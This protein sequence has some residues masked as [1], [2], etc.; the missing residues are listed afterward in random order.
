[1]LKN[2]YVVYGYINKEEGIYKIKRPP[3]YEPRREIE[4]HWIN[5]DAVKEE[6]NNPKINNRKE[7][8]S[9]SSISMDSGSTHASKKSKVATKYM[10]DRSLQE[11]GSL[12]W[13]FDTTLNHM[14][15]EPQGKNFRCGLHKWA[16]VDTKY[17]ILHCPTCALHLY[18]SCYKIFHEKLDLILLKK[19]FLN[20][21]WI[22]NVT[23]LFHLNS[24]ENISTRVNAGLGV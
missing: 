2:E 23:V 8:S 14:S 18:V 10:S 16:G 19:W 15:D 24:T 22:Y 21:L 9:L 5:P 12:S 17:Q 3:Q 6:N 11:S 13:L 4:L 1:M 20:I 7:S